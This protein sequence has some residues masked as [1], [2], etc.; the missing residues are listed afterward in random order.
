MISFW[1]I[2]RKGAVLFIFGALTLSAARAEHVSKNELGLLLGATVTP[3][4]TL[5]AQAAAVEF[6]SGLVFQATY[7]RHLHSFREAAFVFELPFAASP[8]VNL[9]SSNLS[10]PANY[11]F[12]FV[13]LDSD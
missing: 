12:L 1:P 9:S 6:K 10:V 4:R 7:A 8:L 3:T 11:A 5:S 2:L 13:T